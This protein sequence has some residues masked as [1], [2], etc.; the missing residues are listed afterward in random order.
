MSEA[1]TELARIQRELK[2]P[3]DLLNK[4][5]GYTYRSAESILEGLKKVLGGCTVTI[6]DDIVSM[7]GRFYVRATATLTAPD[8]SLTSTTAYA[9]EQDEKK[10]MDA[11]QLTGATSSY[12][13]KYALNGLFAIDDTK[14]ADHDGTPEKAPEKPAKAAPKTEG[15]PA[16]AAQRKVMKSLIEQILAADIGFDEERLRKGI[17]KATNGRAKDLASM[18]SAEAEKFA[19]QLNQILA[20]ANA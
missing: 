18:H 9:R 17:E 2:A 1:I 8:G 14:D 3:K 19:K 20:K 5:G 12:A 16:N 13:R 6:S 7:D 11:A 10:G 4:F 15:K